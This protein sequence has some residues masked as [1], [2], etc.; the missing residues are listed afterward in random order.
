MKFSNSIGSTS[1]GFGDDMI[2]ADVG[3]D[4]GIMGEKTCNKV[5][6]WIMSN[7]ANSGS[8]SR[9]TPSISMT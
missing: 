5:G 4:D 8:S 3:N 2:D 9:I 7:S 1:I 6:P